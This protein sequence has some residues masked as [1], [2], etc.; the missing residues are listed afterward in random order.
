[1]KR[2]SSWEKKTSNFARQ[3]KELR[4]FACGE[5]NPQGFSL[6]GVESEKGMDVLK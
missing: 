4:R 2:G 6:G 3:V 1:M 5:L